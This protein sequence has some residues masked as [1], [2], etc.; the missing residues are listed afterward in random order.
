[1]YTGVICNPMSS[2][3]NIEQNASADLAGPMV[4]NECSRRISRWIVC[5][6]GARE[7]YAIPRALARHQVLDRMFTDFWVP[8]WSWLSCL[9][10]GRRLRDRWHVDLA[11]APVSSLGSRMLSFELRQRLAGRHGWPQ[12]MERN[13]VFQ[14]VTVGML[15]RL[16]KNLQAPT[17]VFSYSYSARD[18]F[19]FAKERGWQTVLGQIDPGPEEE[20]IV[21][22]ESDRYPQMGSKWNP[23]PDVYWDIWREELG[24]ADRIIVNSEWSRQCLLKDGVPGEKLEVVPLVYGV[25][26]AGDQRE[27]RSQKAGASTARYSGATMGHLPNDAGRSRVLRVLF[28]GQIILRKG[29][30]RLLEAMRMLK[31][32]PVELILAGPSMIDPSAWEDLPNVRWIGPV[33]RGEVGKVYGDADCFIL[34]TLSDG[35]ALTQLEALSWGLPVIASKHC[36]S[37]VTHH[38]NGWILDDIEPATISA[39]IRV[40]LRQALPDIRPPEFSI[41][42]LGAALIR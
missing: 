22:E 23:A 36:G 27:S 24:L 10:G 16:E 33:P 21:A 13:R 1:V 25:T 34:P 9:P 32:E 38:R 40:A 39:A 18:V 35:Y 17:T 3:M 41:D 6:N 7:H 20:R 28:L 2:G 42:D 11:K 12:V 30:G 37:A 15:K 8:P 31:D 29:V 19:R 14:E 5:Q 4:S 26:D